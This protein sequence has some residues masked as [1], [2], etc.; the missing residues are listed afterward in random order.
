MIEED[1][2]RGGII[3]NY[4]SDMIIKNNEFNNDH[5]TGELRGGILYHEI[6]NLEFI[7]NKI[8][9]YNINYDPTSQSSCSKGG[10]I[11]NRNA[12]MNIKNNIFNNVLVG[13]YSRGGVIYNNNGE[14]TISDN[15]FTNTV[16][17][18]NIKGLIIFNDVNGKVNIGNN[19]F[20]S[21]NKGNVEVQNDDKYIFNSNVPNE[22]G[23]GTIGITNYI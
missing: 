8:N 10:V 20:E 9:D 3:D 13:N 6:G 15:Q 1:V 18:D 21:K 4:E 14:I 12:T 5:T 19:T 22:E 11:F 2:I 7:D 17:G 16:E 23:S